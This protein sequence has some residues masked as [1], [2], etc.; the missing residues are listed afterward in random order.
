[1]LL[2]AAA[3]F[4]IAAA[5]LGTG[6]LAGPLGPGWQRVRADLAAA[7]PEARLAAEFRLLFRSGMPR[8]DGADR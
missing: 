4:T 3:A 7:R 6:P 8:P 2:K 1:M 5:L